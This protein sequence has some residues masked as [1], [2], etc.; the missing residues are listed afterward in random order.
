[1]VRRQG[2][3]E[4][5]AWV[6]VGIASGKLLLHVLGLHLQFPLPPR[7]LSLP[8]LAHKQLLVGISVP[9]LPSQIGVDE[10]LF[11][12]QINVDQNPL[13]SRVCIKEDIFSV[14]STTASLRSIGDLLE[15]VQFLEFNLA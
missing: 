7:L 5:D 10:D 6:R 4:G 15:L 14:F 12:Q 1:M 8:L 3:S 2:S 11:L 13:L 9:F